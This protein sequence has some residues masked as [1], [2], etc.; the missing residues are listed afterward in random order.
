MPHLLGEVAAGFRRLDVESYD[1]D[2]L[3][4]VEDFLLAAGLDAETLQLAE[5]FLPIER[6]DDNLMHYAVP[7]RCGLIFELRVGQSL[8]TLMPEMP[9][10]EVL[11][12]QLRRDIEEEI[13]EDSARLAA[14]IATGP[15]P[16]I[17]WERSQFGL[18]T[19]DITED[20]QAW[21]DWLRLFGV[22]VRLAQ[23]AWQLE[24]QP[25][26]CALRSLT[27]LLNSAIDWKESR[28]RKAK[29]SRD[30][31]LDFLRPSGLEQRLVQSCRNLLGI[32]LPRFS[33]L[34][35]GHEI[36]ARSAARHQL[37][38]PGDAAHTDKELSRLRMELDVG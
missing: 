3:S 21:Q 29:T 20:E 38:S 16:V 37:I 13:H 27:L 2:A 1:A 5:H 9:S 25:P 17:L 11:A 4:H 23:H 36:L 32:N 18:V 24:A 19:G 33:L 30:N 22:L 34:L 31:L 6:A 14:D 8:R 35:Q 26:G 7:C 28:N 12:K 10:P 15:A